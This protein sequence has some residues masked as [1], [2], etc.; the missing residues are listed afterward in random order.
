MGVGVPIGLR[1]SRDGS[2]RQAIAQ[3]GDVHCVLI[4]TTRPRSGK[5][6]A[7]QSARQFN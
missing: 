1:R 6:A 3:I 5:G 7:P 4:P 2:R